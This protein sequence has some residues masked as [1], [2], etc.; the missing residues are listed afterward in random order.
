M[1]LSVQQMEETFKRNMEFLKKHFPPLAQRFENYQPQAD[2]IVDPQGGIN[3]FDRKK[4]AFLYPGDARLITLKQIAH[5]L[6][7][8][9]FF[10]LGAK[11]IEGNPQWLHIKFINRLVELRKKFLKTSRISL[12]S[13]L[14]LSLLVVGVGLGEHL[15]FLMENLPLENLIVLEPNEDFFYISLHYLDWEGLIQK[16]TAQEG[17]TL[18]LLVGED[19]KDSSKVVSA[20][21]SMGPFKASTTFLYVHYLDSFLR[22]YIKEL[23]NELIRHIS[24]FGF[25]DDEVIALRHTL[26]NIKRGVPLFDPHGKGL[27]P[28]IPAVVVG[29]G[30]SLEFLLPYLKRY[31]DR[32]FIISCGTALGILQKH[33]IKPDL[34]ANIERTELPYEVAVKS[35]SEDFRK[36]I[37]FLG[38]NN[39]YPPF[40]EIFGKSAMF[41]KAGD[42]G[43]DL[44]PQEKLYYVNPTV[45]NTGLALA[46][47][48][49]FRRVY[50]FG[51]DLA[52]RGKKHHAEGSAYDTLLKDMEK[53]LK[54]EIE[55]EGNFG[56]KLTTT[57]IFFA[58]KRFM[59]ESIEYFRSLRE[60]FE[61]FNP[62]RGAKI[63]GAHPLREE[64]LEEHLKGIEGNKETFLGEYWEKTVQ[65]LQ[66]EWFDFPRVKMQLM[67]NFYQLK[68]VMEEVLEKTQR[69]EDFAQTAQEFY[70]Y[71]RVLRE[72]NIILYR[73]LHGTLTLFLAHMQVGLFADV[74]MPQR[75]A[76]LKEAKNLLKEMLGEMEKEIYNL[77]GYFP[78]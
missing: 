69:V 31:A 43:A 67:T 28:D 71:M 3:I 77:Y 40:F 37:P 4:E 65:P 57:S 68:A 61:V 21:S 58:S 72:H 52:F 33:A 9:S 30:P 34:H 42:A 74:P 45:T 7:N 13:P 11:G 23:G 32:L 16:F 25:F 38:A 47:Y 60:D 1:T 51:V 19:A 59:E 44:F 49:G 56:E 35:T 24:F 5:W 17:K 12:A 46:F 78:L 22:N 39:N 14:P 53:L 8:P 41:L 27:K 50:L 29:S 55:V 15:K 76:Y 64:E 63:E 20:F 75:E 26:T 10:T 54:G 62:N 36:G 70:D 6:E 66:R 2:L 48:L 18:T 73:L